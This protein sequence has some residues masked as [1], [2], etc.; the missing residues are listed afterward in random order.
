MALTDKRG[1]RKPYVVKPLPK[2]EVG[3]DGRND[4]VDHA[5]V[6]RLTALGD[7]EAARGTDVL[8]AFW[9]SLVPAMKKAI[10]GAPQLAIW[11]ARAAEV[12]TTAPQDDTPTDPSP[13]DE[14]DPPESPREALMAEIRMKLTDGVALNVI[15]NGL[16]DRRALIDDQDV[17]ALKADAD[18]LAG[19]A[20]GRRG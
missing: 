1:S 2:D 20:R 8:R 14:R 13:E 7:S 6:A 10:G 3:P 4:P 9:G 18:R 5:E 12:T 15:L 11:Q 16:G 19:Q 17:R